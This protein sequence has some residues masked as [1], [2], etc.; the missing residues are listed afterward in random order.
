MAQKLVGMHN[1]GD[2]SS[3]MKVKSGF[4]LKTW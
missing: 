4:A 3:E 1:D 2:E